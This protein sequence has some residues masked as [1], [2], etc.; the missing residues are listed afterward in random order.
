MNSNTINIFFLGKGGVGKSTSSALTALHLVNSGKKVLLASMDPAHNQSDILQIKLSEKSKEIRP[1][2]FAKEVDVN[3]WVKKYLDDVTSQIKHSYSYLTAFNL[4]SY[5]DVIKFSPGIEEY[6]LLTAYKEIR[7]TNPDKD[8]IIFDMPPTALTLKF[9][10]LPKISNLWLEKLL[11]LRN[12]ILK[13]KEII[14]KIQLGKKE[15][16]HDKILNKLNTQITS[17]S[18]VKTVFE[19]EIQTVLNLVMNTDKL[20]FSESNLIVE[21]LKGLNLKISNIFI[22]KYSEGFNTKDIENTFDIKGMQIFPN[23]A[24]PLLGL[25][26]LSQYLKSIDIFIDF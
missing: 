16:E 26:T 7:K 17:Y 5:L 1:N 25:E 22:N 10:G 21:N 6:A 24:I 18:N 12:K 4:E 13:K 23:S 11:D 15:V 2:F 19:N 9:L 3:Y 20:S 14:T 8:Y